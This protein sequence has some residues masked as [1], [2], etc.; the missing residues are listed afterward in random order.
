VIT[1]GIFRSSFTRHADALAAARE[2]RTHGFVVE[3]S[4][5]DGRWSNASR[6]RTPMPFAELGRYESRLRAIASSFGGDYVGF[7]AD[8]T[9]E[10]DAVRR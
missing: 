8:A 7:T 2:S 5:A 3:I 10:A 1:T 9:A 6:G 4:G